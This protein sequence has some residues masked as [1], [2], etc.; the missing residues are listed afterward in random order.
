MDWWLPRV[1]VESTMESECLYTDDKITQKTTQATGHTGEM[2]RVVD[3][4]DVSG[5]PDPALELG[6]LSPL[7]DPGGRTQEISAFFPTIA[8]DYNYLQEDTLKS[9]F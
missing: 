3:H 9:R 5:L 2:G 1:E 8:C 6:K 4:S 7:G